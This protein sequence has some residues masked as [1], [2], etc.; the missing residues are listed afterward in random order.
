MARAPAA[1][2]PVA[3]LPLD[4]C[5]GGDWDVGRVLFLADI[6]TMAFPTGFPISSHQGT[7]HLT[8]RNIMMYSNSGMERFLVTEVRRIR[9]VGNKT[10]NGPN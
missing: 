3:A 7:W 10:F 6:D 1:D 2:A 4:S 9:I 8:Q 5:R